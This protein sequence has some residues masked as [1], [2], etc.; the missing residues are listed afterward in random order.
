MIQ[1]KS[2]AYADVANFLN[3]FS[4]EYL[5]LLNQTGGSNIPKV[6]KVSKDRRAEL[7]LQWDV[8]KAKADQLIKITI[9]GFNKKTLGNRCWG[10][11]YVRS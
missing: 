5:F 2:Q 10:N 8:L 9:P 1:R 7:E 11:T 6:N 3:K 4:A